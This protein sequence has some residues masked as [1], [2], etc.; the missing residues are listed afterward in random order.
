MVVSLGVPIYRVFTVIDELQIVQTVIRLL[1][2]NGIFT[3]WSGKSVP[4]L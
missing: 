2:L 1:S 3:V 4:I